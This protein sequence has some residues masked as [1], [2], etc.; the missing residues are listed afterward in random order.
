MSVQMKNVQIESTPICKGH[1]NQISETN[2]KKHDKY[3]IHI[4]NGI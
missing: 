4:A 1:F 2:T 3:A